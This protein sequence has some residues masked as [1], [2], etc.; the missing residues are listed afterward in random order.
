MFSSKSL[1]DREAELGYLV[2]GGALAV[3]T[4]TSVPAERVFGREPWQ[5]CHFSNRNHV[6]DDPGTSPV[7]GLWRQPHLH[8]SVP[9]FDV[10]VCCV[11]NVVR[12]D[13]RN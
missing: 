5:R 4:V 8:L 13:L 10:N 9:P 1:M 7:G 11:K 3:K 12:H 2:H 6:S